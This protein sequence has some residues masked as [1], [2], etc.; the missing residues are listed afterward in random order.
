MSESL[1][2]KDWLASCVLDEACGGIHTI[3]LVTVVEGR[4]P[5]GKERFTFAAMYN[6]NLCR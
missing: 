6:K 1:K 5:I 3:W 4:W 2:R